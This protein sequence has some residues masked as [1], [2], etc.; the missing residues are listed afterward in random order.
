M[1]EY[2][3]SK[4]F[5]VK[6]GLRLTGFSS[7]GKGT[8]YNFDENY[9]AIDSAVY[10]AGKVIKSYYRLS[11]RFG[12]NYRLNENSSVKASYAR[13]N[14]FLQMASNSTA[15][16]PLDL[17]FTAG[18][19]IK[20]QTCDQYALGYFRNFLNNQ[21][22][23]SVELFYKSMEHTIDFKDHVRSGAETILRPVAAFHH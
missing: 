8:V 23:G 9:N 15:G 18:K 19:N 2:Q 22:E 20:P 17:W 16:T 1:D 12:L 4:R 6:A 14:Q 5:S 11:P 21:L 7:I 3:L 13:T 10:G